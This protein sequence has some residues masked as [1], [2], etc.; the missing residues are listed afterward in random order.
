VE[1]TAKMRRSSR[2]GDVAGVR[3]RE[4]NP[5]RVN[6]SLRASQ[7]SVVERIVEP[8]TVTSHCLTS[9]TA[10]RMNGASLQLEIQYSQ[11]QVSNSPRETRR[12]R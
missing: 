3:K 12:T 1:A 9:L 2:Q 7:I 10:P 11:S 5:F 4:G 6:L 8:V